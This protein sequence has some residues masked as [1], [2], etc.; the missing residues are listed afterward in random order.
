MCTKDF[1]T[2]NKMFEIKMIINIS[3]I[4]FYMILVNINV[5]IKFLMHSL[6]Y[7]YKG[8]FFLMKRPLLSLKCYVKCKKKIVNKY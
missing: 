5:Y 4:F 2:V 7:F 6:L 1:Y 8:I 3:C